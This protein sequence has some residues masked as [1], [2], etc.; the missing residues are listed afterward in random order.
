M[1]R[2]WR[3][4]TL[5]LQTYIEK[6]KKK[7]F[8]RP[9]KPAA[10]NWPGYDQAQI[11]EICDVLESVRVGVD[12]VCRDLAPYLNRSRGPGRPREAGAG[13]VADLAKSVLFQQYLELSNRRLEGY[14]GLF[15]EKLGLVGLGLPRY[16][17]AERA[18]GDPD[19]TVV[20]LGFFDLT[21]QAVRDAH[22][23]A[24][25]G[26]GLSTSIKDSWERYLNG[27]SK[28]KDGKGGRYSIFEKLVCVVE[29]RYGVVSAF[30]VLESMYGHESPCFGPLLGEAVKRH[31]VERLGFVCGDAAYL[32]RENCSLVAGLGGVPRFYPKKGV[33]LRSEGSRAYQE[34]LL[35]FV[36][37]AQRWLEEYHKRYVCES[38][39]SSLKRRCLAPLRRKIGARRKLEV[40]ARI[41]VYNLIRLSYARWVKD[42]SARLA[43]GSR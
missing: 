7:G 26:T 13:A 35:S 2:N 11:H 27:K 6:G 22:D 15:W 18:Y 31:G 24:V 5:S 29:Q 9:R 37:D 33:S 12:T 25:D 4:L 36:D 10:R 42:L 21:V 19:V 20:L 40:V 39:F 43:P 14:L 1:A 16:K 30:R 17:D 8:Y 41:C 34:M 3:Q 32:S 23:F 28:G 38:A